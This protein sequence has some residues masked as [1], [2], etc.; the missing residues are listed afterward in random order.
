MDNYLIE[1]CN[2]LCTFNEVKDKTILEVGSRN[3]NGSFK[4]VLMKHNPKS[5]LGIDIQKGV[6][7]DEICDVCNLTKR[8][9]NQCF[10]IVVC[11]EV[12]EHV[13][14]WRNGIINL[15]N[16]TKIGG[17]ILLTSRSKG[18]GEHSFPHD[19]WRF[20]IEDIQHIFKE[21]EILHLCKDLFINP[22]NNKQDHFGFFLKAKKKNNIIPS[23]DNYALFNIKTDP[24]HNPVDS[25]IKRTLNF[26]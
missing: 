3:V 14:D 5:Y 20:E 23:L 24:R 21:W 9:N 18:F 4:N 1:V 6:N 12:I 22:N 19:Y 7:V 16:V 15:M 11:T 25:C 17:M 10:D 8:F 26:E 13:K 2:N